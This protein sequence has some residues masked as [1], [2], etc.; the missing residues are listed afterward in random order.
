MMFS[1]PQF[2]M[3]GLGQTTAGN[4][5]E[6]VGNFGAD[7]WDWLMQPSFFSDSIPNF[8]WVLP[9][10]VVGLWMF[11]AQSKPGSRGYQRIASRTK[12]IKGGFFS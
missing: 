12:K 3:A 6:D 1:G 7:A 2:G 5:A 9:A 8:L 4:L 11:G 10:A